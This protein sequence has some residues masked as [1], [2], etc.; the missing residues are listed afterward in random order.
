MVGDTP[1]MDI[2]GAKKAGM[3][4]ILIERETSAADRPIQPI[5]TVK[6][7]KIIK[8]MEELPKTIEDC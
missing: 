5:I 6:P 4:A 1:D 8:S 7:D 2:V 3:K